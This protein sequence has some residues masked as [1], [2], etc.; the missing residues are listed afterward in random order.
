MIIM[1]SYKQADMQNTT[2][3]SGIQSWNRVNF[4]NILRIS[5]KGLL[6][7]YINRVDIFTTPQY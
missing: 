4:Q 5:I 1:D 2:I 6:K 7:R 3:L